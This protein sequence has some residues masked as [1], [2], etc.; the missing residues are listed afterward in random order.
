M[1]AKNISDKRFGRLIAKYPTDQRKN[2]KVIW[3]CECD[4]GNEIDVPISYLTS[5]WTQSCGC[6]KGYLEGYQLRDDYNAKRVNG[7]PMQLFKGKEPRKDSSTG[8]R[9]VSRYLTRKSKEER[10]RAWITVKGKR[11][12][13]SGFLTAEDAYYRGRL[14]LEKEYLPKTTN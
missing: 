1:R 2:G 14:E 6:L 11:Y 3:H 13:K 4:C 10:Y 7:V 9:G 8:Y 5:E 12:Y